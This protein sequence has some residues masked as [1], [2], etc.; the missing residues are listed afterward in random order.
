M[1]NQLAQAKQ[2]TGINKNRGVFFYVFI[3]LFFGS[4]IYFTIQKGHSLE[5]TTPLHLT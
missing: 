1:N 2:L 3:M 5:Q 4:L